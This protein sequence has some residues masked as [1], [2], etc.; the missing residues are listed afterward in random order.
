MNN[1][2]EKLAYKV[3][4]ISLAEWGRKEITINEAAK[5][6]DYTDDFSS[7]GWTDVDTAVAVGT[8]VLDFNVAVTNAEHSTSYDVG[9]ANISETAWTLRWKQTHTTITSGGTSDCAL[10][11]GLSSNLASGRTAQNFIGLFL[12]IS[13]GAGLEI[14]QSSGS[15]APYTTGGTGFTNDPATGTVH[16]YELKRESATLASLT[17]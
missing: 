1:T 12:N 3:K 8:N 4:D 11:V 6:A 9:T 15:G 14:R 17:I 5:T 7:D 2:T 10:H 13:T 16:Y